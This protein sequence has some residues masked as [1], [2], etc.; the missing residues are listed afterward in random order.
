[1]PRR[2]MQRKPD[3]ADHW[4][5]CD[6]SGFPGTHDVVKLLQIG[7]ACGSNKAAK[8]DGKRWRCSTPRTWKRQEGQCRRSLSIR[9]GTFFEGAK[10]SLQQALSLMW[11]WA[12]GEPQAIARQNAG[13]VSTHGGVNWYYY[14]RE[15]CVAA[16]QHDAEVSQTD[17]HRR[18]GGPEARMTMAAYLE[19]YPAMIHNRLQGTIWPEILRTGR[20][21]VKVAFA[22]EFQT[23]V[24]IAVAKIFELGWAAAL[25]D[26][27]RQPLG[28]HCYK[29]SSNA[30]EPEEQ[31]LANFGDAFRAKGVTLFS[32]S[33]NDCDKVF[34]ERA[35][36]SQ[37][38][39]WERSKTIAEVTDVTRPAS[40]AF[41][42]RSP[43]DVVT[44]ICVAALQNDAEVSQT[45]GQR[46]IGGP[47]T[48]VGIDESKFGKRKYNKGRRVEGQW[49]FGGIQR[50]NQQNH[51]YGTVQT[52]RL[53]LMLFGRS[54]PLEH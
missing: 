13:V 16:L 18:I 6:V 23:R 8:S 46:R 10:L 12:N 11:G 53:S 27:T 24:P 36:S 42:R 51:L 15:I 34:M 47:G 35:C 52:Q 40:I 19:A 9:A 45:D 2:L 14:C 26:G 41:P 43:S 31:F 25:P 4:T 38:G 7:S 50:V 37:P 48:I 22:Y 28:S 33:I 49:V 30:K 17:G 5:Y 54:S 44:G 39:H 3:L 21:R 20:G 1:M 29:D 32:W